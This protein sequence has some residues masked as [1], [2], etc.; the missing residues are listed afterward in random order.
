MIIGK[1]IPKG[2]WVR[3]NFSFAPGEKSLL[4][5]CYRRT[6]DT[7]LTRRY[8]CTDFFFSLPPDAEVSKLWRIVN[9][10]KSSNVELMV[11]P[12]RVQEYSYLMSE[13]Y[14]KMISE[15]RKGSFVSL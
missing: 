15:V 11:H 9:L 8:R 5:R 13:D 7:W 12:E 6:V 4:N 2:L 1:S 3:R 10:A 14:M